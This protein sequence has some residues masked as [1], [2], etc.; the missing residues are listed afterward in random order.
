M[1]TP[2]T[3]SSFAA[4]RAARLGGPIAP[5]RT[6]CNIIGAVY[7]GTGSQ[8]IL[9]QVPTG[10]T[11]FQSANNTKYHYQD[12][13]PQYFLAPGNIQHIADYLGHR[14]IGLLFNSGGGATDYMDYAN[15]GITNPP[16]I[17]GNPFC[18]PL[19]RTTLNAQVATVADDDGGFLR[20]A[21]AS[22][23][24]AGPIST[25]GST[26]TPPPATFAIGAKV[27][28]TTTAYV[29]QN[30]PL[31]KQ[32]KIEPAGAL[33]TIGKGPSSSGGYIWWFVSFSN[34]SGWV[35]QNQLS[36]Q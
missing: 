3:R 4:N 22:Y 14:V 8:S 24:A 17:C 12:N 16:P 1:R 25:S 34:A 20:T 32:Y 15:D 36:V 13:R 23:Y 27:E 28:T 7:Q 6:T 30:K 10:N 35:A 11:L 19:D 31:S 9:W 18:N 33:G 26:S 21:A 5:S 2:R 29:Y